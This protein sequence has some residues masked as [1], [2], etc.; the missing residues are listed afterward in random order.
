[1]TAVAVVIG[2]DAETAAASLS[3]LVSAAAGLFSW[4]WHRSRPAAPANR[5]ELDQAAEALTAM[6]R[7]QWT[8]EAAAGG[9]L[10]PHPLAVRWRSAQAEAGD[11]VRGPSRTT[12]SSTRTGI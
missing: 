6:V 5:T 2:T 11:H 7:R 9:L 4:S 10:H 1:V 8:E 12:R 3:L